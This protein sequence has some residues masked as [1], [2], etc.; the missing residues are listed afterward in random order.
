MRVYIGFGMGENRPPR[1]PK[2]RNEFIV[3]LQRPRR[4]RAHEML[5]QTVLKTNIVHIKSSYRES[6]VIYREELAA[7]FVESS[8]GLSH[9]I[10]V[11][12]NTY[13]MMSRELSFDHS[14]P[15]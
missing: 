4:D 15:R 1:A 3:R 11:T 7:F 6:G 9:R 12:N 5:A 13:S 10:P 14:R 2:G 8:R